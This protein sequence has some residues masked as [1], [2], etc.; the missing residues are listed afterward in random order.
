MSYPPATVWLVSNTAGRFDERVGAGL[1]MADHGVAEG[2][3]T[4][5]QARAAGY[6]DARIRQMLRR[7]EWVPL[8][9]GVYVD[10]ST[11][12]AVA[13]DDEREH[14]LAVAGALLTVNRDAVAAGASA[15]RILALPLLGPPPSE[16]VLASEDATA[17]GQRD[18][19]VLRSTTLPR[20]HSAFRH[21]VAITSAA[22]TVVDLA[23][24]SGF[25]QGVVAA[26]AALH[27]GQVSP[28][29]LAHVL[30]DCHG[31]PGI[32]RARRAVDFADTACESPLESV[33]RVAIHLQG[34][35]APRTQVV[36]GAPDGPIGRVD[37]LWEDAR[38]IG[39]ADGLAKYRPTDWRT[40][41]DI[42]RAEK[43]RE[44]RL[45]DLGYEV[46]RWGW[47]DAN[48]PL[49]LAH[50]LR[51]AFARGLERRRGRLAN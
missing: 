10:A 15:A 5:A 4:P 18:G 49:Q 22:R 9:R 26:D 16:L 12:A 33:S 39:E 14:A 1:K 31:W 44:E 43:R 35:P 3:F 13:G 7:G 40:T 25:A 19:Y 46:V 42:V 24:E 38:V 8:R 34:L 36:L 2:A 48:N 6:S 50:R 28:S 11:L 45:A 21:G 17:S 23:R 30:V 51:A 32:D 41:R 20:G 47:E 29:Q 37:F 27:R